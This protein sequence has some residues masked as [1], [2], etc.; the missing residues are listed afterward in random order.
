MQ[1]LLPK[2]YQTPLMLILEE[3]MHNNLSKLGKQDIKNF[4]NPTLCRSDLLPYLA[5]YLGASQWD[6]SW[7]EKQKR[8]ILQNAISVNKKRGTLFALKKALGDLKISASIEEWW[9]GLVPRGLS[10]DQLKDR[11][12]KLHKGTAIITLHEGSVIYSQKQFEGI[13]KLID[14]VK[15]LS[16][17]VIIN[18]V[19]SIN[20]KMYTAT[21]LTTQNR[22]YI[23]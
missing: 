13:Y 19:Q 2:S 23:R 10:L 22:Q 12:Q 8:Q 17:Q 4:W 11:K 18:K 9:Q 7:E 21:S 20:D 15:R 16:L 14:E 3:I 6:S 5:L 1:S